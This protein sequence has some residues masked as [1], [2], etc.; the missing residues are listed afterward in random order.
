MCASKRAT[1]VP[2]SREG[3]VPAAAFTGT[4]II[5]SVRGFKNSSWPPPRQHGCSPPAIDMA[6]SP[7]PGGNGRTYTSEMGWASGPPRHPQWVAPKIE[8]GLRIG[9]TIDDPAPRLLRG[10]VG[11]RTEDH[12]H[13]REGQVAGLFGPDGHAGRMGPAPQ[14]YVERVTHASDGGTPR[15]PVSR[16]RLCVGTVSDSPRNP[17][18]TS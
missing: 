13:L 11:R 18:Q 7:S 10:H 4:A 14:C 8:F 3:L 6:H 9:A 15:W 5:F 2:G 12:A 17:G 16:T 1:G